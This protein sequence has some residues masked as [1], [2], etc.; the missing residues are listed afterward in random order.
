MS[1][2]VQQQLE[3]ASA[4]KCMFIL[5]SF[6]G[7]IVSMG[8]VCT[9]VYSCFVYKMCTALVCVSVSVCVVVVSTYMCLCSY[10]ECVYVFLCVL[11]VLWFCF[12]INMYCMLILLVTVSF[13]V[14]IYDMC[15]IFE[16]VF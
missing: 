7:C 14:F 8:F 9:N 1:S 11:K 5:Y 13:Y 16:C 4:I 3:R 6:C 10:S 15:I 2:D 12:A